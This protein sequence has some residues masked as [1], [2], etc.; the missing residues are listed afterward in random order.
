MDELAEFWVHTITVRTNLGEGG[1]GTLW[2][3]P[4]D[5]P[6]FIDGGVKVTRTA[7]GEQLVVNAP[8]YAP[9][10]H[11][12]KLTAGS[13]VTIRGRKSRILA[14]TVYDSSALDLPDHVQLALT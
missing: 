1:N 4:V 9:L 11:A 5:V 6:C 14:A 2:S 12:D 13:Q 7:S 8:V 3:D 10:E